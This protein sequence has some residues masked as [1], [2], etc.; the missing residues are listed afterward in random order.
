LAERIGRSSSESC[1]RL[2]ISQNVYLAG[3]DAADVDQ[4][5][6]DSSDAVGGPAVPPP[7]EPSARTARISVLLADPADFAPLGRYLCEAGCQV[8][9]LPYGSIDP[10]L[11]WC[12]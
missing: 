12:Y 5:D 1:K 7:A 11:N 4:D 9:V 2:T 8:D 6:D 10:R 3:D